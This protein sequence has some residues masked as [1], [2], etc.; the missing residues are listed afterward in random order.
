VI[1]NGGIGHD[2]GYFNITGE[3]E[4]SRKAASK[5][6]RNTGKVGDWK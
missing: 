3:M 6:C 2:H 4:R 1:Q 5:S